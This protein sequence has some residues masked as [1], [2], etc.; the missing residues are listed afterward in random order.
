MTECSSY[1]NKPYGRT[2]F[3]VAPRY[4]PLRIKCPNIIRQQH[5]PLQGAVL[6]LNYLTTTEVSV[7]PSKYQCTLF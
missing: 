2:V 5:C 6:R 4:P 3:P 7:N 1:I